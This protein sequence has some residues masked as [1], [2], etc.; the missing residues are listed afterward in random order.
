MV[1]AV[2]QSLLE[3]YARAAMEHSEA[4]DRLSSFVGQH[5][6]FEAEKQNVE[7][8]HEKCSAAR[9]LLQQHCA[10][11]NCRTPSMGGGRL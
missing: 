10:Q 3:N 6:Q 8:A 1:C 5:E 2:A 11:H 7:R 4:I 9:V